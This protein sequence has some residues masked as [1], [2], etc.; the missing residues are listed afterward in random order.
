M[1]G[2]NIYFSDEASLSKVK[3]LAKQYDDENKELSLL[4]IKGRVARF[5]FEDNLSEDIQKIF[6]TKEFVEI[7]EL[8][9]PGST[10]E[11]HQEVS[12][13]DV[14]K[15]EKSTKINGLKD[16]LSSDH[17]DDVKQRMEKYY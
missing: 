4:K 16:I 1:R 9:F 11:F 14:A 13:D 12:Q 6:R 17:V 15:K 7:I 10:T 8:D 5:E 2:V 3:D